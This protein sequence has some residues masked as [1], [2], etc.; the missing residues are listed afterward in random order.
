[1]EK[2]LKQML[3]IPAF[4]HCWSLWWSCWPRLQSYFSFLSIEF[5]LGSSFFS[6]EFRLES[7]F[8]EA[9]SDG[10]FDK[11]WLCPLT[12]NLRSILHT[13]DDSTSLVLLLTP[14]LISYF[15]KDC[16]EFLIWKVFLE[17]DALLVPVF[18][19]RSVPIFTTDKFLRSENSPS[20]PIF[21]TDKI[22][23]LI[24]ETPTVAIWFV[25]RRLLV[26]KLGYLPIILRN[27]PTITITI[28]YLNFV[29]YSPFNAQ[30]TRCMEFV[31]RL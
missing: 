5:R 21:T 24:F 30:S 26:I 20:V 13:V 15:P 28:L 17:A 7:P 6:I 14:P 31:L 9:V 22:S 2:W 16:N 29:Y 25:Y 19:S 23:M 3:V 10:L 8:T 1:M 4:K 18:V 11:G 12:D 27:H